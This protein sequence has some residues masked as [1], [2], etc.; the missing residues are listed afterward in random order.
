MTAG[1]LL[2]LLLIGAFA[3]QKPGRKSMPAAIEQASKQL[4]EYEKTHSVFALEDA[5]DEIGA[6]DL[7]RTPAGERAAA[8]R[9]VTRLWLAAFQQLDLVL[10]PQFN[11]DDMPETKVAPPKVKGVAYP[12]GVDPKVI[13]DPQ[14]RAQYEA[15]IKANREKIERGNAQLRLHRLDEEAG[16]KF[17]KFLKRYYTTAAADRREIEQLLEAAHLAPP[18]RQKIESALPKD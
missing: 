14:A 9:E 4:A 11:P 18:R 5:F 3:P 16:P 2:P 12:P 1:A 15:A 17:E 6:V 8:R 10:D 7:L 13:P